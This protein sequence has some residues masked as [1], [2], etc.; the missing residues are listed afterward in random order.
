MPW[1]RLC[2]AAEWTW[3]KLEVQ[4]GYARVLD[5]WDWRISPVFASEILWASLRKIPALAVLAEALETG[6]QLAQG[7]LTS[8]WGATRDMTTEKLWSGRPEALG[9]RGASRRIR[10]ST[11]P[12]VLRTSSGSTSRVTRTASNCHQRLRPLPL[13]S[14]NDTRLQ[15]I[16]TR[17]PR[18]CIGPRYAMSL[19]CGHR[20]PCRSACTS[21]L[22]SLPWWRCLSHRR[23]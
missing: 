4:D 16:A 17:F 18:A 1:V 19:R 14:V 5:D 11:R 13:T 6:S 8:A 20:R 3:R 23:C 22:P 10:L 2:A 15:G 9:P 12:S 7:L 21:S